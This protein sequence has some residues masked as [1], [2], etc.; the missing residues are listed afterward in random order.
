MIV[1][2]RRSRGRG[3]CMAAPKFQGPTAGLWMTN[4]VL[5]TFSPRSGE[6]PID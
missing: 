2:T 4:A 5:C 1:S 3:H 6:V